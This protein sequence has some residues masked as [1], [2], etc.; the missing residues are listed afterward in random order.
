[1]Q[2]RDFLRSALIASTLYG[3]GTL[4]RIG[5]VAQAAAFPALGRRL[6]INV[7][8]EGG[9]DLRYLFPPAFDADT[10]SFG[11]RYWQAMAGA[12]GIGDSAAEYESRWA[13]AYTPLSF[14]GTQFGIL[15]GCEWL[16]RMWDRGKVAIVCNVLNASSRNH[17]HGPV[18]LE[19][20][21]RT[22]GPNDS[23]GS[24]WG[25]R[26]A[27]AAGGRALALTENP[28]PFCYG[29]NPA[30]PHGHDNSNMIAARDTRALTLFRPDQATNSNEERISRSLKAYYAAMRTEMP[31][32]SVFRRFVD[33]E[34]TLRELGEPIDERLATVPVPAELAALYDGEQPVLMTPKFGLQIRNVHDALLCS[35]ILQ[36]S[37]VSLAYTGFDTHKAQR[38]DL[39]PRLVDMFGDG[40]AFDTLYGAVPQDLLDD[41]VLVFAGEFGRQIRANG[42]GGSDHG[43][44][45][46][47]LIIGE[48]VRGGVYGSM[49]PEAELDRLS[50]NSPQITGETG[51]EALFGAVCDWVEPG[52]GDTVFPDRAGAP[53][54]GG[55]APGSLF[56]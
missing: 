34:R 56:G 40:M 14:G 28:S 9:P 7:E 22:L 36:P 37:V 5:S 19:H 38:A 17:T 53:V 27:A 10:L 43:E 29:P 16:R 6:L 8:L 55:F 44:G 39:E 1:M 21:D 51:I 46:T 15:N 35:D 48:G 23:E 31:A 52:S 30:D 4:P 45:N 2:R 42:D 20:G 25:G 12:H 24:G 33:V 54:E 49:F 11:Y 3:L 47:V 26:L 18:V 13:E 50:E 32:D 41:V